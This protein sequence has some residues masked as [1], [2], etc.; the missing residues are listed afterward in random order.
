[1]NQE[2]KK[3]QNCKQDFVIEPEDFQFY[4]KMKVPAPTWCYNCR[5]QRRGAFRNQMNLYSVK[6]GLCEKPTLAMY[7]PNSPFP[8]YCQS[9]WWSDNWDPL[10]YGKDYDFSRPFF[11]QYHEL[12]ERTPRLALSNK[13]AVNSEYC[14][15]TVNNK[16]CYLC[17]STGHSEDCLYCGPNMTKNKS[18]INC[19]MLY[20][21]EQCYSSVDCDKCYATHYGQNSENCLNSAFLFNCRNVQDCLGCVNLRNKKYCIFNE[22]FT[23]E[24][25][26]EKLKDYNLGSHK[27]LLK[28]QE[29]FQV[30]LRSQMHRFMQSINSMDVSG[31]NILNSKNCKMCFS[32]NNSE[33]CKYSYVINGAHD[34]YDVSGVY[35]MAELSYDSFS[36]V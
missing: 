22:Q 17:F 28:F 35:P 13:N 14:N 21:S 6:C 25:Y 36:I 3:C 11:V 19:A 9:C 8:V 1:M 29:Q 20:N 33:N 23:K 4:E 27:N 31:D 5:F 15:Y 32:T 10:T 2:T 7:P 34:C 18:C 24:E 30:F 26:E 12:L 16:N